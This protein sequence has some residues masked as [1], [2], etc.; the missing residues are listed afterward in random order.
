MGKFSVLFK[1]TAKKLQMLTRYKEHFMKEFSDQ[2]NYK[3]KFHSI[4]IHHHAHKVVFILLEVLSG[5]GACCS[6]PVFPFSQCRIKWGGTDKCSLLVPDLT[7]DLSACYAI[8]VPACK[9][10]HWHFL[11]GECKQLHI[12]AHPRMEFKTHSV[13]NTYHET[14]SSRAGSVQLRLF[15][16]TL[17]SPSL[18]VP[19][20]AGWGEWERLIV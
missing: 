7:G 8:T 9:S 20:L 6:Y 5:S 2:L 17:L 16:V 13:C 14:V 3:Q 19:G 11:R 18:T 4:K 15:V 12:C 1:I 10:R